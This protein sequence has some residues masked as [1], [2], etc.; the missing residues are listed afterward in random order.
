[1]SESWALVSNIG[2]F[3]F[4]QSDRSKV[5]F[6]LLLVRQILCRAHDGF[7]GSL[8][9]GCLRL[10]LLHLLYLRAIRQERGHASSL[11]RLCLFWG[12]NLLLFRLDLRGLSL[13][14]H[15]WGWS[16]VVI[17]GWGYRFAHWSSGLSHLGYHQLFR[18][19][20]SIQKL[21]FKRESGLLFSDSTQ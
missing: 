16:H 21:C 1:M 12:C 2:P 10:V 20:R 17:P 11:S 8:E 5:H 9:R 19:R 14:L 15:L 13:H 7:T 18:R 3:R 4:T 6:L